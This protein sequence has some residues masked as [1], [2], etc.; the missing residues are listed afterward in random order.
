[1]M[2][3][4]TRKSSSSHCSKQIKRRACLLIG[5]LTYLTQSTME[6]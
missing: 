6:S 2:G 3:S 1:M 5:F 4:L